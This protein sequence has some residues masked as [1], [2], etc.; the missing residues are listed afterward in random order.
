MSDMVARSETPVE[1]ATVPVLAHAVA[2]KV[3][4]A[5]RVQTVCMK[6]LTSAMLQPL[7]P[8][9]A[10]T[11]MRR[12]PTISA[13][14]PGVRC[15]LIAAT[16]TTA[17]AAFLLAPPPTWGKAMPSKR[18]HR[19]RRQFSCPSPLDPSKPNWI[20]AASTAARH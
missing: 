5:A 17:A 20:F 9:A 10:T 6:V 16:A 13:A 18:R 12:R 8:T 11:G 2:M 3:P 4:M 15:R 7:L 19:N 14:T 1:R